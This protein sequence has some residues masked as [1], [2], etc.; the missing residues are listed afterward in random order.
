MIIKLAIKVRVQQFEGGRRIN[1]G[2]SFKLHSTAQLALGGRIEAA[3]LCSL[4]I[5]TALQHNGGSW[6][7][8]SPKPRWIH[9]VIPNYFQ[10]LVFILLYAL[11][12][13]VQAYESLCEPS[14]PGR[15]QPISESLGKHNLQL[16]PKVVACF[17]AI[18][19][20][21]IFGLGYVSELHTLRSELAVLTS[22]V[23]WRP[24]VAGSQ[25]VEC[26]GAPQKTLIEQHFC[27]ISIL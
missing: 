23:S 15:V 18:A 16:Q 9:V 2:F 5:H 14:E 27:N 7:F 17:L 1:F 11:A 25:I 6:R 8:M 21:K 19:Q 3:A 13:P 10:T 4:S 26:S 22:E 20:L 24:A 12:S